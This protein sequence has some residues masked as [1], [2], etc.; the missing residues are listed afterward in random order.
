MRRSP[1]WST[2]QIRPRGYA[3]ELL[4]W[5]LAEAA[6]RDGP[7]TVETESLTSAQAELFAARGLRQV[8]AED[9]MRIDLTAARTGGGLAGGDDP[10]RLVRRDR[11]AL[12][13]RL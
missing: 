8:F 9:V 10:A 7:V 2:R 12:L 5:G 13:R 3:A 4:D 1:C 6:R 11:A